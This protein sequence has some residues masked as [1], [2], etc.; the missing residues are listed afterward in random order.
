MIRISLPSPARL[1]GGPRKVRVLGCPRSY[2]YRNLV[3]Q[4][5]LCEFVDS[6]GC[7][8]REGGVYN[9][10]NIIRWEDVELLELE[11]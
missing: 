6:E 1:D 4:V 11:N 8:A 2:W 10:I 7:W 5:V 9:C 3:G